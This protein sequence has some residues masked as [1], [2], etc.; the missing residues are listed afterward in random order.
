M[1]QA[2]EVLRWEEICVHV[3]AYPCMHLRLGTLFHY[4]MP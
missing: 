2:L 3:Q 4:P 1:R